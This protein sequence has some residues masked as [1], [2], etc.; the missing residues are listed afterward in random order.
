MLPT[1]QLFLLAGFM[2]APQSADAGLTIHSPTS[3]RAAAVCHDEFHRRRRR[4]PQRV[5]LD[6]GV[7]R[8]DGNG[9]GNRAHL[10]SGLLT[11]WA[12][13]RRRVQIKENIQSAADVIATTIGRNGLVVVT[14]AGDKK[15]LEIRTVR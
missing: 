8:V 15:R 13:D 4:R 14:A 3:I 9:P 10:D 5:R 11:G 2:T 1:L 6:A 7:G 12:V